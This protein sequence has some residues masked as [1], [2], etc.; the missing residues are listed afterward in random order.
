MIVPKKRAALLFDRLMVALQKAI[1]EEEEREANEVASR[2][3]NYS[4]RP[5]DALRRVLIIL[6]WIKK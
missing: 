3:N 5:E 1:D 6:F 4:I 2:K